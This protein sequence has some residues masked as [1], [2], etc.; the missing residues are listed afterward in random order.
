M[1]TSRQPSVL[2]QRI[3]H[4]TRQLRSG[5]DWLDV[6]GFAARLRGFSFANMLLIFDQYRERQASTRR[7]VVEPSLL[8]TRPE[9]STI[10]C[11]VG[12]S[13]IGY[14]VFT[15]DRR[16]GFV[17][18]DV[19]QLTPDSPAPTWG[20]PILWGGR[21]PDGLLTQ[22]ETLISV[23]GYQ[24][25]DDS[26][27]VD[28]PISGSTDWDTRTVGVRFDAS[29]AERVRMMATGLAGLYLQNL[30]HGVTTIQHD[31][32]VVARSAAAILCAAHGMVLDQHPAESVDSWAGDLGDPART[33]SIVACGESARRVALV[34]LDQ[35]DTS[36]TVDGNLASLGVSA[37]PTLFGSSVSTSGMAVTM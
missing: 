29:P 10:G 33:Q 27:G 25:I 17:V 15:H 22:L 7:V 24:V 9:W 23:E 2:N 31:R 26:D 21:A 5:G 18:C 35:L 3:D 32:L 4:A 34:I 6:M 37:P 30:A 8:A 12:G 1:N 13:Q 19:T 36:Q 16:G 28:D 11:Q 20:D 14:S